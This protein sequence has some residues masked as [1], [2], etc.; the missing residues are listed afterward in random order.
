MR[1]LL[2]ASSLF[3]GSLALAGPP[4]EA[5]EAAERGWASGVT[6]PDLDLLGKVLGDDLTYTHS[7]GAVDTK[8]SYIDNLRTGKAKYL[9]V[10]YE[11]LK[12]HMLTKDTAITICRAKVKTNNNG[13]ASDARLSF[14]HV[15]ANR[16]GHW[17][18]VAH[19]SARLP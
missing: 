17:E 11:D 8:A 19:Q 13:Q 15:F 7:T 3:L 2:I 1:F 16:K 18:L 14:L 4:E 9:S 10:D 5:V 12:V 6:K